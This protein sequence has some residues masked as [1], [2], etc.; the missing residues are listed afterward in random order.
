MYDADIISC[1]FSS[2]NNSTEI[3]GMP[4]ITYC[5]LS[6]TIYTTADKRYPSITLKRT[7]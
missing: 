2:S 5:E 3:N 6:L 4:H 1:A 7:W